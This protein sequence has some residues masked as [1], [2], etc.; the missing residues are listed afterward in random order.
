M[1]TISFWLFIF[2]FAI[3]TSGITRAQMPVTPLSAPAAVP[4]VED[5]TQQ[6][7]DKLSGQIQDIL[8]AQAQQAKRIEALE[9]KINDLGDKLN[10]PGA[11]SDIDDLKKQVQEIDKKRQSDN[12]AILKELEKLD[13][14]LGVAP[15][16]RKPTPVATTDN[17]ANTGGKQNGF[18]YEIKSGD[19]LAAIA[20]AYTESGHK[21]T[22]N[23]ILAANR[24]LN[25]NNMTVGKK[26]F[27]PDTNAK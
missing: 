25:P 12:E 11:A 8:D 21:V 23:Q 9:K 22:V 1:R 16:G 17:S 14:A 27:I 2:T 19:T 15:S 3:F 7:I 26:I 4:V 18:D 6:Q 24:G 10:Q 13:K 20:K 5:A